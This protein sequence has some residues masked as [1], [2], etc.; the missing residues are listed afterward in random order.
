MTRVSASCKGNRFRLECRGHA[1]YAE[2]GKDVIC[3]AVSAICQTLYLWCRNTEDVTIE[4][5]TMGPG[6]FLLTA[7][8]PCEEPWK[9]AVLGL[10]SLEAGYPAYIR[11]GAREFDL[12]SKPQ[13]RQE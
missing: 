4:D 13:T 2:S 6:V 12:C 5:E 3:A 9:A 11:V 10:M 1:G 8:G 7:S